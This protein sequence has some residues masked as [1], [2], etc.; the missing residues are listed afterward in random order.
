[1][2]KKNTTQTLVEEDSADCVLRGLLQLGFAGE[3]SSLT[4][5]TQK[6]EFSAKE[7]S[8]ESPRED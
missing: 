4:P 5:S 8:R 7:Q 6:W 3:R 1:L 2:L